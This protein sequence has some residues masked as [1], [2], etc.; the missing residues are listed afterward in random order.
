MS[1]KAKEYYACRRKNSYPTKDV[2]EYKAALRSPYFQW[3]LY[4]YRCPVCRGYH[5]TKMAPKEVRLGITKLEEDLHAG[6][7]VRYL[8]DSALKVKYA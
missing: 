5:L 7:T 6:N 3:P 8:I 2:A 1:F 4:V